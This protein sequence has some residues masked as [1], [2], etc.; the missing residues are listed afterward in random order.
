[1]SHHND[2]SNVLLRVLPNAEQKVSL[3]TL[4]LVL[5]AQAYKL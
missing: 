4:L 2:G 5:N 3:A 1:M